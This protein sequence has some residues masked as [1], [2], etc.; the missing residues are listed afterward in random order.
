MDAPPATLTAAQQAVVDF[1]RRDLDNACATDLAQM[2]P[3]RLVL[4]VERYRSGGNRTGVV[5]GVF[6]DCLRL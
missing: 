5:W 1:A 6:K 2:P 3:A 4:L